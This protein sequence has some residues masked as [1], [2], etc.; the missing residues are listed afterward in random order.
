[1]PLPKF[2]SARAMR[3][4][5]KICDVSYFMHAGINPYDLHGPDLQRY[6]AVSRARANVVTSEFRK[7]GYTVSRTRVPFEEFE[8]VNLFAYRGRKHQRH[9]VLLIAHHDY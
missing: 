8:G 2:Q 4:L 3:T 1:M 7:L 9:R 6:L 5:K